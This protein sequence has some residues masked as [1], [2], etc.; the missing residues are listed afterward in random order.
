MFLVI[1]GLGLKIRSCIKYGNKTD[2]D[3]LIEMK[4][5]KEVEPSPDSI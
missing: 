3:N 4:E 5:V 1:L 2:D